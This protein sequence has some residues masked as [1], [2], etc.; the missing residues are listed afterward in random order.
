MKEKQLWIVILA[1]GRSSRM[2]RPK[3]LLPVHGKSMLRHAVTTALASGEQHVAVVAA[4]DGKVTSE[5]TAGLPIQWFI[6]EHPEEGLS[7]SIRAGLKALMQEHRPE[8]VMFLLADQP[9]L[10]HQVI[11]AAAQ[12]YRSTKSPIVQVKYRDRPGH[13]VIFDQSMFQQL[14][15]IDG[16]QGAKE[17]ITKNRDCIR[18]VEVDSEMPQDVDTPEEYEACIERINRLDR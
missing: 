13:P 7:S 16:D 1:A 2:G 12:A 9:E 11:A 4:D 8:A 5:L 6:N 18:W 3:Q 17:V 15:Q 14:L 10:Q